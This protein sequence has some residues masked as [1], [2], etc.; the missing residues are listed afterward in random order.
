M[1][2]DIVVSNPPYIPAKDMDMLSKDVVG[3]E[4]DRA[5]CGGEDGLDII[6][7]IVHR[8]PEWTNGNCWLEV[9]DSHPSL[10]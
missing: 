4:S 7:H 2:F 9:D 3:Y 1:D 5:L 8:L 10:I 6:R